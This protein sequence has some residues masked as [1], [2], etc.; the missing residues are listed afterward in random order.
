[1][2][3]PTRRD[4]PTQNADLNLAPIMNVVMIL[5]PLLL[6]SVVFARPAVI[7]ITSPRDAVAREHDDE[8]RVEPE[9]PQL[10]VYI[11]RRNWALASLD[12]RIQI[13]VETLGDLNTALSDLRDD[14]QYRDAFD[15]EQNVLRVFAEP[16][17]PFQSVVATLDAAR[18]RIDDDGSEQELFPEVALLT[19]APRSGG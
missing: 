18:T 6:L 3:R 17:V 12:G 16:E 2:A 7:P 14:P 9:A 19:A 8:E 5:I 15:R 10:I 1:M 4:T 11:N 13:D